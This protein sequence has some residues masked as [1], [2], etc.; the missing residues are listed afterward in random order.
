MSNRLSAVLCALGLAACGPGPIESSYLGPPDAIERAIREY[1]RVNATEEVGQCLRPY[2]DGITAAEVVEDR[3]EELVV[4]VRYFFRDQLVDPSDSLG[5]AS[6]CTGFGER[7]FVLADTLDG[8]RVVGMSGPDE[9]PVLRT[10]FRRGWEGLT[11][12]GGG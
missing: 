11:G 4:R 8:P 9:E 6:G 10:L 3:P 2:M 1:Y 5:P 7:I 12:G